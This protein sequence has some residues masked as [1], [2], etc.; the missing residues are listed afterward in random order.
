MQNKNSKSVWVILARALLAACLRLAPALRYEP[1]EPRLHVD[2]VCFGWGNYYSPPTYK[3]AWLLEFA[4]WT[5]GYLKCSSDVSELIE[6][7]IGS[8]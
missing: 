3:G 7:L 8:L 1:V 2:L 6:S 4:F 5:K